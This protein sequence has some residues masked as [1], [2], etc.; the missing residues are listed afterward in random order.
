M[1]EHIELRVF[2][3]LAKYCSKGLLVPQSLNAKQSSHYDAMCKRFSVQ[4]Y[5]DAEQFGIDYLACSLLK[6]WTG[7]ETDQQALRKVTQDAWFATERRV[8][9]H[10]YQ[11]NGIDNP[12]L[13]PDNPASRLILE[14]RRKIVKMIGNEPPANWYQRCDWPTGATLDTRMDTLVGDRVDK[15]NVTVTARAYRFAL[16]GLD[17]FSHCEVSASRQETVPKTFKVHRTIAC[18]PT[19]NAYLQKGIGRTLRALLLNRC[20]IDLRYQAD[21]NRE[22]C[23]LA[24]SCNLA[25]IDLEAA[26]DTLSCSTVRLLLPE[27]WTELLDNLRCAYTYVDGT[28]VLLEK[29]ASMGNGFIFELETIIFR[30]IVEAVAEL[31]G[32]SHQ[33]IAVFGDD[34]IC[35]QAISRTVIQAL[36]YFGFHTNVEKTFTSGSFFESCGRHYFDESDVTPVFQKN[37]C[38]SKRF[39]LIAFH[40]R[41]FRWGQ[42]TKNFRISRELCALIKAQYTR[43]Y[44]KNVPLQPADVAGDFGFSSTKY[45]K[46]DKNGDYILDH[47]LVLCQLTAPLKD[48]AFYLANSLRCHNSF[49][50]TPQGRIEAV[51]ES[52]YRLR[53]KFRI[54]KCGVADPMANV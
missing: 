28:R 6:K 17:E 7:W 37:V 26:S 11:L 29:Y 35:H 45:V 32:Y 24:K 13:T 3:A 34:I 50:A 15:P 49:Y 16:L 36:S 27:A 30:S 31:T 19:V 52:I 43:L 53:K 12:C 2:H 4:S 44:P 40:N 54:W 25:T 51:V 38:A 1:R 10:N 21:V 9:Q 8:F 42:R 41:V 39:E 14:A 47:A 22:L 48:D 46:T 20:G 18:E 5:N 23:F 33:P